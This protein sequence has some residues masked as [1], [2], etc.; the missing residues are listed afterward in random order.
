MRHPDRSFF[1]RSA[2]ALSAFVLAA[3]GC[4]CDGQ[5]IK[6]SN[7]EIVVIWRD[8]V[9][10]RITNRDATYDFGLALVG[11]RKNLTMTLRNTGAAKLTL[12]K[13]ELSEGD[14]VAIGL[15]RAVVA[16]A[17]SSFEAEF[18]AL[19]LQPNEQQEFTVSFTPRG[20]KG[21]YLSKLTAEHRG[22][23]RRRLDRGHHPHRPGREGRVRSPHHHRLRQDA[24]RR[25]AFPS[26]CPS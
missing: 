7:G 14:E 17:T 5:N 2:L 19:V 9:G 12:S 25:D 16:T 8:A 6:S 23:A 26:P 4:R 22:H 20:L 10:D 11:Q 18:D 1:A 15:P 24:H 21:N 13:L 3:S